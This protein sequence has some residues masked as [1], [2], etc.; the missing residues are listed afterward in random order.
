MPAYS[1]KEQFIDP[2]ENGT[3]QQTIRG[4]RKGQAKP[5]DTLY[6]YYGMRTKY[7]KK[8]AEK[9]CRAVDDI[10]IKEDGKVYV[11]GKKLSSADRHNLAKA[12][13]FENFA[14][15]FKFWQQHNSLPFNG[16]IIYW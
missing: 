3:K 4:K 5:G 16:D 14:A 15:M 2:I 6:L 11:N 13:G 9:T 10:V 7:C 8:I 1:F 12:D